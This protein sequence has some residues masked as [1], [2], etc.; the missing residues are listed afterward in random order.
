MRVFVGIALPPP[1]RRALLEAVSPLR[2]SEPPVSW[3][4]EAN[5]H[6]TLKFLGEIPPERIGDVGRSLAAA[7]R[8]IAPFTFAVVEGGAFPSSGPP[9]VLWAGIRE[10]A[11]DLV[12]NLQENIE[13]ALSEA[14][15]PRER[16]AFHPHIT[17]GRVRGIV[18]R[19]WR[20]EYTAALAG[21]EF[22]IVPVRSF[23]LYESRLSPAGAVYGVV[24]DIPLEEGHDR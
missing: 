19:G 3:T 1:L 15:F 16:K 21:K 2:A 18:P 6:M 10:E 12:G 4:P 9:R 7:S 5:L 8:G 22:G 13:I 23:Q 14:G 24:R 11:L 20:E 17:I